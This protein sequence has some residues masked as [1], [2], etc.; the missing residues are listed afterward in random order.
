[1][2]GN[3]NAVVHAEKIQETT[4]EKLLV[5]T[6]NYYL[7]HASERTPQLQIQQT[8]ETGSIIYHFSLSP[9][10]SNSSIPL[11]SAHLSPIPLF[12]YPPISF[13]LSPLFATPY[14]LLPCLLS[15]LHA[16]VLSLLPCD[17]IPCSSC[18][19]LG[20]V[21]RGA[22]AHPFPPPH[23]QGCL[24]C[25]STDGSAGCGVTWLHVNVQGGSKVVDWE[26]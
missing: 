18:Q 4:T 14:P 1:M 2:Y 15:T 7:T 13:S 23:C 20:V 10:P 24:Y 5:T 8:R 25:F 12:P 26:E 3:T 19:G 21:G 16:C 17:V 11:S 9:L 6:S 22:K